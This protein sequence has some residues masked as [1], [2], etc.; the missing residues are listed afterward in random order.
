MKR[1]KFS[2]DQI[3]FAL[4]QSETGARVADVCR[5]MGI[6][7]ATFYNWKKKRGGL[8]VAE[9]RRLKQLEEE[10]RR[11]K[12]MVADLRLDTRLFFIQYFAQG[13]H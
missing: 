10:N 8:G 7:E 12:R 1:S 2:D 6:F 5:K 9:V 11:L 4:R 3:T 13:G